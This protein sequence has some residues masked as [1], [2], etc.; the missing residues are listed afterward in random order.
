M[1][2]KHLRL[3]HELQSV[4]IIRYYTDE[5][6]E[7]WKIRVRND[8]FM[9]M[10]YRSYFINSMF[11]KWFEKRKKR[12]QER[13]IQSYW[14]VQKENFYLKEIRFFWRNEC[15]CGKN[16]IHVIMKRL[17]NEIAL[18]KIKEIGVGDIIFKFLY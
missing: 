8:V 9:N 1:D 5:I 14:S 16:C 13:K 2:K 11:M 10:K 7:S 18:R 6:E 4:R 17:C 3:L 15:T 12:K